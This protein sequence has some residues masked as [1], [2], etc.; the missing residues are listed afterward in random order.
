[1]SSK[2]KDCLLGDVI[3]LKR[4]YDLPKAKRQKGSV[5]L[6]SSAGISDFNSQV[7][8]KGPG[9]VTGRYGTIGNVYFIKEDFFPLNTTLY[10][11][12]FKGNDERF[13][14]Y[15]LLTIDFWSCADKAAVPGVNRNHLH[16]LS[17]KLPPLS[18]QKAI[19]HILGI[20]DEK[21]ELNRKINETL[22]G[23]AKSLFKS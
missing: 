16:L 18:E 4:G 6:V 22:E 17:T 5:P 23:I 13:I 15:F 14:S 12:D 3:N 7:K 19:A 8:V 1:M 10:V 9:V 2:W 21:I 20:F 11:Q